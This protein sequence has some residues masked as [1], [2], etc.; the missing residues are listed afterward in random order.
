MRIHPPWRRRSQ[1]MDSRTFLAGALVAL[2]LG[3]L[4]AK[5][6][7]A[8]E[9]AAATA[10]APS[11]SELASKL[12][13]LRDDGS[14]YVRMKMDTGGNTLQ[15]QIKERSTKHSTEVVY[16]V[17]WPKERK[18]ESVLVKKSSGSAAQGS[19]FT[20]PE[21]VHSIESAR[22]G[23]FGSALAY[24]D[25]VENFYDWKQQSI[26]GAETVN[27]VNCQI[28]ESKPGG[29]DQSIYGKVKSWIDTRRMV[30]MRVE[31]YSTSGQ[32]VRRID[33]TRVVGEGGKQIPA[34]LVV[35]GP[36]NGGQT[37]ID[38]S[39]IRHDVSYTDQEFTP[40]GLKD[41]NPPKGGG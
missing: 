24:A 32:L 11:G 3:I 20:P 13:A 40:A 28:L 37:T 4:S 38:G 19:I 5:P 7:N 17:L 9:A 18:G 21:T 22:E 1:G 25:L 27:G 39:K 34:D 29:G 31:K 30:P 10:S 14:S 33:T 41:L 35:T 26:T 6:A 36:G 15:I 2:S 12:S 16:Q 23:V 8:A